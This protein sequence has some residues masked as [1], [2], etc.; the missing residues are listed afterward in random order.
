M[1]YILADGTLEQLRAILTIDGVEH[2]ARGVRLL[3][4]GRY[5]ASAY[6][7]EAAIPAI[8]AQGVTVTVVQNQ[9]DIDARLEQVKAEQDGNVA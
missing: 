6:I 9:V 3:A 8:Q 2:V 7:D 5:Q 4:D 1:N